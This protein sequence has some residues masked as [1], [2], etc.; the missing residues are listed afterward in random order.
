MK[1]YK[2]RIPIKDSFM[3]EMPEVH[4]FLKFDLQDDK[5]YLWILVDENSSMREVNFRIF[6]T[7]HE[8]D[9]DYPQNTYIGTVILNDLPLVWHLFYEAY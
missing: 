2:Y 7:G 3:I 8:I 6:G 4:R 9:M 1:I 5:P